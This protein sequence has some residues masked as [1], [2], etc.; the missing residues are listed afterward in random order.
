[1]PRFV[2]LLSYS[3]EMH[4]NY[5]WLRL[6]DMV[7][8]LLKVVHGLLKFLPSHYFIFSCRNNTSLDY[9]MKFSAALGVLAVGGGVKAHCEYE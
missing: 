7:I 1:M 3:G 4:L 6:Y 2:A 5:K 8:L 9:I